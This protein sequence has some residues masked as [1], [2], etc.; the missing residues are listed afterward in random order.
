MPVPPPSLYAEC[1]VSKFQ[2]TAFSDR[3][4]RH[5]RDPLAVQKGSVATAQIHYVKADIVP[6]HHSV[7]G[8]YRTHPRNPAVRLLLVGTYGKL[9]MAHLKIQGLGRIDAFQRQGLIL[10]RR[11]SHQSFFETLPVSKILFL[12]KLDLPADFIS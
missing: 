6:S 8:A 9:G 1:T 10:H 5:R 11:P 7:Q 12:L 3:Y 2:D 4:L